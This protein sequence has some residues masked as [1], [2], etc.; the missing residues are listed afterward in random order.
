MILPEIFNS[1]LKFATVVRLENIQTLESANC[2][3]NNSL[4]R[5]FFTYLLPAINK[6]VVYYFVANG[7]FRAM[8]GINCKVRVKRI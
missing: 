8:A 6:G 2:N 7:G 4:V 1:V 3:S 5:K